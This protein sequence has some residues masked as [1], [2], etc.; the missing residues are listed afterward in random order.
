MLVKKLLLSSLFLSLLCQPVPG[1]EEGKFAIARR[2]PGNPIIRPE[3]LPGNDGA[4]INGPS[5]IR[6]PSWL[7]NRLGT[8]YLYFA[9]HGGKYIRLA[10][11]DRLEGPWKVHEPGT[12]QLKEAPGCKGHIASPDVHVDDARQEI[13]MYFHGPAKDGSGQKSFVAVSKDGLHFK[14]GDEVLGQFYF[15]VFQWQN[16]WYAM[17][18]GGLLYRS[19]DGLTGFMKG[20]NPL[21]GGDARDENANTPGPRHVAIHRV[22]NELRVHYSNIG[23]EPERILR[24]RI[25]LTGDWK[26][27]TTS[28]SEEA[29][30]PKTDYEG[31]NLPLKPSVAGAMKGRENALRDPGIFV[32]ADGRAYLL[33]SVAGESG[34]GIAELTAESATKPSRKPDASAGGTLEIRS[35]AGWTVRVNREFLAT[36]AEP[37]NH[38]LSLLTAQLE[39]ITRVVPKAVLAELQKVPLYVSPEYPGSPPRAEYHPNPQWLR[40]HGRDPAMAK[41]VE[42]TNVRILD[43]ET[44]RMPVFALH[45]LAHAYHDRVLGFNEPRIKTAF[46]QAKASS[47]YEHVQRRDARGRVSTERAY[48]MTDAKEYFAETTE[49]LF[50]TNDFYPFTRD[51]L[52]RHDPG[53]FRLLKTIWGL[54]DWGARSW[55]CSPPSDLGCESQQRN[56]RLLEPQRDGPSAA[57][58]RLRADNLQILERVQQA[59]FETRVA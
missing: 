30:R 6:A 26:T 19:D 28:A 49:A 55:G 54:S 59:N 47:R 56:G 5:L 33:Y 48:A 17:A 14:A 50:G 51:E 23:D 16:A 1:G 46:Q 37:V 42:F 8:Y 27:W 24:C 7:T 34:I 12:L 41:G 11:A 53:M 45:E 44:R 39:G 52:E 3:M 20:N 29:L 35:L 32:D 15:R 43:A 36:N 21:P 31:A 57:S 40:E 10:C 22:G 58:E 4:N 2:L 38:A 18:K 13:R 25:Q 9:H